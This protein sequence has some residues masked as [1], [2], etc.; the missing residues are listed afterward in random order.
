MTW[1][2]VATVG[3]SLISGMAAGDASDAQQQ[4]ADRARA[5]TQ[6]QYKTTRND[7]GGYRSSGNS[8]NNKLAML[9]GTPVS[10]YERYMQSIRERFPT[11]S[12]NWT[13]NQEDVDAF[14]KAYPQDSS[15]SEFG[16]LLKKYTGADLASEPG[17]Q[18]RQSEGQK[19]VER[20]AAGRGGLFS[21]QAG[22]A[23]TRFNQDF[24]S[25]EYQNAFNRDASQKAQTYG[26]LS[27]QSAQGLNAATQTGNFGANAA[28]Q[29]ANYTTQGANA[30]A[31]GI[32]GQANA[33]NGG[34]QNYQNYNLLNSIYNQKMNS[35]AGSEPYPG[36]NASIGMR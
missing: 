10:D 7:L 20:S 29:G 24:A 32:V 6:E 17:Y 35:G 26:M 12:E 5:Q 34:I 31:A 14:G 4:G 11:L 27:G 19:G 23:L 30:Q 25:N 13:P 28:A 8:A 2:A 18:F 22:K 33:I 1:G 36:Y 21:G 3:G 16:S 9:L 15:S